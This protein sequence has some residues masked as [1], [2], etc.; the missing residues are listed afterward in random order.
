MDLTRARLSAETYIDKTI[1]VYLAF[2]RWL[3]ILIEVRLHEGCRLKYPW[4]KR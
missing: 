1:Y 2:E 3:D 4:S